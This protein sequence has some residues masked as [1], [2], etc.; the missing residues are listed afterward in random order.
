M[1]GGNEERERTR[2]EE[3]KREREREEQARG[4]EGRVYRDVKPGKGSP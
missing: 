4:P 2:E 1:G 3:D